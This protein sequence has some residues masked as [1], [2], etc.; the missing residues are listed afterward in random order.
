MAIPIATPAPR[1][2]GGHPAGLDLPRHASGQLHLPYNATVNDFMPG[3]TAITNCAAWTY[4][5]KCTVPQN[6]PARP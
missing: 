6:V 2:W 4:P 3:G 1:Y 5:R